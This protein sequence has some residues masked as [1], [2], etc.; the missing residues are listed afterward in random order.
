[1]ALSDVM[2][3]LQTWTDY[4]S[5]ADQARTFRTALAEHRTAV[6]SSQRDT[7]FVIDASSRAIG[8]RL[9]A[10][11]EWVAG[12]IA[13]LN[14]DFNLLMGEAIWLLQLQDGHLKSILQT[15]Q[16]PLDTSAKELRRRAERAYENGW[17]DEAL[18][19]FVESAN[20]NYQDFAVHRSIAN[21]YFF[22]RNEV[23]KAVEHFG[24]AAKYARTVD[25]IQASEAH[26][27]AGV[28]LAV[29]KKLGD[30]EQELDAATELNPH[31]AEAFYMTAAVSALQRNAHKAVR[32]LRA[33]IQEDPRYFARAQDDTVVDGIREAVRPL[34]S[35]LHTEALERCK[36]EILQC[37]RLLE[38]IPARTQPL[39]YANGIA[40]ARARIGEVE[41]AATTA[42]YIEIL[43]CHERARSLKR[44]IE[45][46][47]KAG[48]ALSKKDLLQHGL[49]DLERS[50]NEAQ[51]HLSAHFTVPPI[52]IKVW[53]LWHVLVWLFLGFMF[54][55]GAENPAG[56]TLVF[57][58]FFLGWP[59]WLWAVRYF[60][61]VA[62]ESEE[63]SRE[64]R[65]EREQE[66]SRAS[67]ATRDLQQQLSSL[68]RRACE[69]IDEARALVK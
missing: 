67:Q 38:R 28:A 23:E 39:A 37:S 53:F 26:Y 29:L 11:L 35:Q 56:T 13:K 10:G 12:G 15:L 65:W 2:L 51:R 21:I 69:L 61:R 22:H 36:A 33:A 25:A 5:T 3:G 17:Y 16:A 7:Q 40:D 45:Q 58:Y 41:R 9:D 57:G 55:R 42:L 1:M 8:S 44:G 4:V 46:M 14:A 27:Y 49:P 43:Q 59:L 31:F 60:D 30:A 64:E 63:A 48:D 18:A 68:E 66:L 32:T 24:K 62:T 20:R 50:E 6:V 19:D 47:I 34:L 52:R 54:M